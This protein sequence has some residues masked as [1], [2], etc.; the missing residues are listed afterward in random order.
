MAT[1]FQTATLDELMDGN[2]DFYITRHA[3]EAQK[4]A[5]LVATA[6]ENGRDGIAALLA[7]KAARAGMD[8]LAIIDRRGSDDVELFA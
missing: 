8:A 5:R 3:A 7:R 2:S 4:L 6:I 1:Y